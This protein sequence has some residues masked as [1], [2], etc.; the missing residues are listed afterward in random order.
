MATGEHSRQNNFDFLRIL[1]AF[2]VLVS[3]QFSLNGL[4]EPSIFQMSLAISRSA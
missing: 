4:P 3:H 1:A 2:L